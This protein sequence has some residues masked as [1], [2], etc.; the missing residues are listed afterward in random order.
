MILFIEFHSAILKSQGLDL[1][2][3]LKQIEDYGFTMYSTIDKR[4]GDSKIVRKDLKSAKDV[5]HS[6]L[7]RSKGGF[8]VFF[9]KGKEIKRMGVS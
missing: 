3:T 2:E 8:H 6:S 9:T 7:M 4:D 5:L 1:G